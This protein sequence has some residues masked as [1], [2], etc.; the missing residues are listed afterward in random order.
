MGV[1]G[2]G[3]LARNHLAAWAAMEDVTLAAV[4][5]LDPGKA[6]AAASQLGAERAYTDAVAM[7]GTATLSGWRSIAP[8]RRWRKWKSP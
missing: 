7:L 8:G 6:A 4:C 5:D 2:C 1:I 3:F